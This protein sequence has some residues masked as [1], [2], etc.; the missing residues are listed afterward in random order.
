MRLMR[1]FPL[2]LLFALA[3]LPLVAAEITVGSSREEL[4]K[5]YG[6]PKYSSKAG[7][8]EVFLTGG[9]IR[10]ELRDGKVVKMTK[11]AVSLERPSSPAAIQ[12]PATAPTEPSSPAAKQPAP[13]ELPTPAF[14]GVPKATIV[15]DP[16]FRPTGTWG[17]E[18]DGKTIGID[19]QPLADHK[20]YSLDC[21]RFLERLRAGE[22]QLLPAAERSRLSDLKTVLRTKDPVAQKREEESF[23][24]QFGHPAT[25]DPDFAL[26]K[27]ETLLESAQ[28]AYEDADGQISYLEKFKAKDRVNLEQAPNE[29]GTKLRAQMKDAIA[30]MQQARTELERRYPELSEAGRKTQEGEH[31][32]AHSG[33]TAG[34]TGSDNLQMFIYQSFENTPML[35]G[36]GASFQ[37]RTNLQAKPIFVPK[38]EKVIVLERASKPWTGPD[39]PV[40]LELSRIQLT[41]DRL[42]QHDGVRLPKVTLEGW[43]LSRD[44]GPAQ[45]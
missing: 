28:L 14:N 3:A 6:L 12:R 16:N 44:L 1:P 24:R 15:T 41:S 9:D 37:G 33:E 30:R 43:V 11:P 8:K 5:E 38:N 45:K 23:Q 29:T 42:R 18:S 36:L 10:F 25:E 20:I 27:L 26:A 7:D 35:E 17:G 39:G 32:K 40:N 4:L 19:G 2:P 21:A 22:Q 13:L 31:A 34:R